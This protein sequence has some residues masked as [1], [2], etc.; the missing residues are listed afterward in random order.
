V[1]A[2]F[3]YA[4][5]V[6][7]FLKF[8]FLLSHF[9]FEFFESHGGGGFGLSGEALRTVADF[10]DTARLRRNS[11]FYKPAL[12]GRVWVGSLHHFNAEGE[13]SDSLAL[14]V[15]ALAWHLHCAYRS[16]FALSEAREYNLR[17]CEMAAY[18]H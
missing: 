4:V 11:G 5:V 17:F 16:D 9:L 15:F 12:E 6:R 7:P 2:I 8:L 10:A 3:F 18:I 1:N 14:A 13:H